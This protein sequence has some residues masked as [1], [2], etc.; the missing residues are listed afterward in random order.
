[1]SLLPHGGCVKYV[2]ALTRAGQPA[3]AR[4]VR[5]A[6]GLVGWLVVIVLLGAL[7]GLGQVLEA[8][9]W[10]LVVLA[11][12]VIVLGVLVARTVRKRL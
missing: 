11:V 6:M 4:V 12:V 8:A 5:G 10:L 1:V 2:I 9:F 7:F 3:A